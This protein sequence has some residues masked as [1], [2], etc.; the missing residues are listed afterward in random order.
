MF[1]KAKQVTFDCLTDVLHCFHAGSALG[2]ASG[3]RRACRHENAVLVR[4]EINA[5]FDYPVS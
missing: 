1:P 4:F 5:V 2:N 3:Q